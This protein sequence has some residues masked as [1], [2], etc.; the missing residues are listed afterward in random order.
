MTYTKATSKQDMFSSLAIDLQP[1]TRRP[2]SVTP[3]RERDAAELWS[4]QHGDVK[5][6][7]CLACGPT[8]G[9]PGCTG[10]TSPVTSGYASGTSSSSSC[11]EET[12]CVTL[13]TS[14]TLASANFF[15]VSTD[16]FRAFSTCDSATCIVSSLS[17][18]VTPVTLTAMTLERYVAICMPL[19]HG[20]LCSTSRALPCLLIIHVLSFL[21]CIVVLSVVFA[22]AT[23]SFYTQAKICYVEMLIFY[24]WQSYLRSA[25]NQFYFMLMVITIIF[26]YINIIKVAKSASGENK[27]SIWKGIKTVIFHG[28][29]LLLCL[30]QLWCPFIEAAVLLI[31][32]KLYRNVRY[33]NYITFILAP[34]CLSPLVYGIRDK[35]FF[36]ALKYYALCGLYKSHQ[37][38][39]D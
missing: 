28:F 37:M 9:K 14:I 2:V 7:L 21:P 8:A 26:C 35:M 11:E 17:T 22:S 3:A 5:V 31:N 39:L 16:S 10:T 1:A 33:F 27:K 24:K 29:Q 34:R 30:F 15:S 19:R 6:L 13:S 4:G 18:F 25:I 23:H 36:N 20:E 32:F 38:C 12:S